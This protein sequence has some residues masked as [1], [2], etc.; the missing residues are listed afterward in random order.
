M[1]SIISTP[2]IASSTN[3]FNKNA[4]IEKT[5]RKITECILFKFRNPPHYEFLCL[6]SEQIQFAKRFSKG[7]T[8]EALTSQL[9]PATVLT[10]PIIHEDRQ[11]E[12]YLNPGQFYSN[13][14]DH[15]YEY[16]SYTIT[17]G[18][19]NTT[20]AGCVANKKY[21]NIGSNNVYNNIGSVFIKTT[22]ASND[23]EGLG[24]EFVRGYVFQ[25]QNVYPIFSSL[26]ENETYVW[27]SPQ[28]QYDKQRTHYYIVN[29][30]DNDFTKS[31]DNDT[32]MVIELNRGYDGYLHRSG[33]NT[34]I[35]FIYWDKEGKWRIHS[36][37][38]TQNEKRFI[39]P[40]YDSDDDE[41]EYSD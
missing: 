21:K 33:R 2:I 14:Y 19:E 34:F 37:Q 3:Q 29:Y 10:F 32:N 26:A 24:F 9:K 41:C 20:H 15:K 18:Y 30:L 31:L 8:T 22:M 27:V 40:Y 12:D 13:P 39:V 25:N 38:L 7:L 35:D 23:C 11:F 16:C 4:D 1:N 17:T 36:P 6:M 5:Y 28:S